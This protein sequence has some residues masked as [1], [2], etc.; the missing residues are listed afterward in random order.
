MYFVLLKYYSN[1][2]NL[3]KNVFAKLS[4]SVEY[5]LHVF[6]FYRCETARQ[7]VI[8]CRL[9][10]S[11]YFDKTFCTLLINKNCTN[12]T[13]KNTHGGTKNCTLWNNN[14][15]YIELKTEHLGPKLCTWD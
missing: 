15:V 1:T 12:G 9:C 10:L 5:N 14:C 2:K 8:K 13:K 6:V 3:K 4:F 7:D 11:K